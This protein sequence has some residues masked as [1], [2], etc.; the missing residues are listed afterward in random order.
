MAE[1]NP[2]F[3]RELASAFL[4]NYRVVKRM[5]AVKANDISDV[6]L[7][8]LSEE[9]VLSFNRARSS[10]RESYGLLRAIC[11]HVPGMKIA[12]G[13]VFTEELCRGL[14]ED[15]DDTIVVMRPSRLS[16]DYYIGNVL[17]YVEPLSAIAIALDTL[18]ALV[19]YQVMGEAPAPTY[20]PTRDRP[21]RYNRGAIASAVE[22]AVGTAVA[23]QANAHAYRAE[24]LRIMHETT[25]AAALME[26]LDCLLE[27]IVCK[28]E[29]MPV[30]SLR[31]QGMLAMCH[32]GRERLVAASQANADLYASAAAAKDDIELSIEHDVGNVRVPP[33]TEALAEKRG[34][35]A[36][37]IPVDLLC[38][39]R[40]LGIQIPDGTQVQE[41][42]VGT[43]V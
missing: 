32:A 26:S 25:Q 1:R 16:R 20:R 10:Y 29:S 30:Q 2:T 36:I 21:T 11:S 5:S 13:V 42:W 18:R 17:Y 12:G 40:T 3:T 8:C 41:S 31:V 28:F 14:Y 43:T 15:R 33:A 23:R 4:A 37:G 7:A 38:L 34:N 9:A 22:T 27:T 6:M 19:P 24:M 35:M 39:A